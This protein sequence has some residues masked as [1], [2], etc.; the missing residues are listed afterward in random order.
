MTVLLA[1]MFGIIDFGRAMYT[2]SYV[3][4]LARQG[5][6]WAIVRGANCT[7]Y[8]TAC[9]ASSGTSDIQP[10]IQS[11][12]EGAMD[13]SSIQ[14]NLQFSSN[15]ADCAS[16]S[17]GLPSNKPGCIAQ[18]TVRYPFNFMLPWVLP[19]T[20]I[21]M[22]STSKMVN[23]NYCPVTLSGVEGRQGPIGSNKK[24]ENLKTE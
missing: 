14:A 22:Q 17:S 16:E 3:A 8:A 13:T 7:A 21:T 15:S 4:Q 18:V 23:A 19:G 24:R 20:T 11:L 2:Y 12:N 10:Y 6:R 1:M 9:P 5:A